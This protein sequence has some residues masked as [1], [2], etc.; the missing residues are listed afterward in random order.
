MK[1]LL[2]AFLLGLSSLV[3]AAD[4]TVTAANVVPSA[5]AHRVEATAGATI[6]AGQLIYLDATDVD[7]HGRGKAKLSD[8]DGGT[9]AVR[10]V[11]GLAINS[12][13]AGQPVFYVTFDPDLT[14]GGTQTV[15]TILIQSS[16]AGGIAPAADLSTG[17]YLT[18]VGV[19]KSTTKIYFRVP[20]LMSGVP[21]PP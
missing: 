14:I 19:V 13:S 18:V 3:S 4:I 6:A 5:S 16:T 2:F 7:T 17:E 11:D 21:V 20:G 10:V 8:A 15:N 12:A 1:R 9:A